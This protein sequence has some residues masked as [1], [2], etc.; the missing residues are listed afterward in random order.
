MNEH[1]SYK[2]VLP[3]GKIISLYNVSFNDTQLYIFM[4]CSMVGGL[5][6]QCTM[7]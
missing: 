2:W 4:E 6:K 7:M 5:T 3:V 1:M